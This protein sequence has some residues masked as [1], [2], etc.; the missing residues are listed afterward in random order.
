MAEKTGI[1]WTDHTQGMLNLKQLAA[2]MQT[3]PKTIRKLVHDGELRCFQNSPRGKMLFRAQWFYDYVDRKTAECE[4]QL[5]SRDD[6]ADR[7]VD[8][9]LEEGA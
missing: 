4:R 2:L 7:L 9:I 6:R 8:A 3:C 5:G 1:A